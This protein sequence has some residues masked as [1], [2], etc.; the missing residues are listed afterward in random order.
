MIWIR[1]RLF[2]PRWK[3]GQTLLFLAL[4]M[5]ILGFVAL[6]NFDLHKILHVKAR[7]RNAGDY[8][9][10]SA[11]RWQGISMNVIGEL[12]IMQAVAITEAMSRGSTDFSAA[13][14]IAVLEARVAFSGPMLGVV[15]A[16]QVAKKNNVFNNSV[17]ANELRAHANVVRTSYPQ[18]YQVQGPEYI[19]GVSGDNKWEEYADM[20]E[21]AANDGIAVQIENP[22]LYGMYSSDHMLL[23]PAFYDAISTRDWCWF[24]HNAR[25]LLYSYSSWRDWD[26]L[27]PIT[28]PD[29]ANSEFLSLDLRRVTDLG[30]LPALPPGGAYGNAQNYAEVMTEILEQ[31][32]PDEAIVISNEIVDVDANWFF[33]QDSSWT[34]WDRIIPDNFPWDEDVRPQYNYAGA[35]AAMRISTTGTRESHVSNRGRTDEELVGDEIVWTA[36]AKAFG[37]LEGDSTPNYYGIVLPAFREVGLIPVDASTAPAG[38]TQPGWIFFITQILPEYVEFGVSI[39]G[40]YSDNWYA[41]QLITWENPGFRGDGRNWLNTNKERCYIPPPGGGGGGGGGGDGGTRR[42][43]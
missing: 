2:H 7:A 4:V 40:R 15:A 22:R 1:K 32:K 34:S 24:E 6:W 28:P 30:Q 39:L 31:I 37:S 20:L 25:D 17:F 12:N 11:A 21:T 3:S 9:A 29:P 13:E 38:G 42:G 10:L 16:Q 8:A 35:D 23:N 19:P 33:Y 36:A 18:L 14:A 26:P 27:P 43:H 41:R 5:V